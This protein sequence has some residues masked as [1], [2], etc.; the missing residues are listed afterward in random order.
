M[1]VKILLIG[2]VVLLALA[3]AYAADVTGTWV[4]ERPGR[5]GNPT[6]T[7]FILKAEGAKLTGTMQGAMGD[8]VQIQEGKVDG[9]NVSF[10]VVRNMGGNEMKTT[11]K[12]VVSGDELKLTPEFAMPPGGMGGGPGAGGPPPGAGAGGGQ[13]GPGGAMGGGRGGMSREII[14]KR[15]K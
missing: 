11:Y 8:P 14:A 6:K 9:D 4:A 15:V 2:A 10:V 13:G 3:A 7:T 12:G 1:K 5:D